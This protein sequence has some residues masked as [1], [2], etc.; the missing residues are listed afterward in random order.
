MRA[1][2]STASRDEVDVD[3][4]H[5]GIQYALEKQGKSKFGF[6][7]TAVPNFKSKK[8]RVLWEGACWLFQSY[9]T[10]CLGADQKAR[11]LWE[12]D[13][14][15]DNICCPEIGYKITIGMATL[16]WH[17]F[18]TYASN[19]KLLS[20]ESWPDI[21]DLLLFAQF[22]WETILVHQLTLTSL[23][24]CQKGTIGGLNAGYYYTHCLLCR[25]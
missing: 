23:I 8:T 6:E 19:S 4:F 9:V 18:V 2:V 14:T 1:L 3:A 12:R 13:W 5:K 17:G 25:P 10:L 7:R 22:H 11:G 21:F 24:H 20:D 15:A 16:Y